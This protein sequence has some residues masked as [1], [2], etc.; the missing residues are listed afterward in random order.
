[1]TP[2]NFDEE[3]K[4]MSAPPHKA[5][6]VVSNAQAN[7]EGQQHG[8][9]SSHRMASV[10]GWLSLQVSSTPPN[11]TCESADNWSCHKNAQASVPAFERAT[12]AYF[13]MLA[14]DSTPPIQT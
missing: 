11:P 13:D 1:V 6:P 4:A 12:D 3:R 10:P 5:V 7:A 2:P 9:A 14:L 8:G